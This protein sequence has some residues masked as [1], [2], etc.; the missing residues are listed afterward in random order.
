LCERRRGRRREVREGACIGAA[1]DEQGLR[2]GEW[3]KNRKRRSDDYAKNCP[4]LLLAIDCVIGE[5]FAHDVLGF[6]VAMVVQDGLQVNITTLEGSFQ[7]TLDA[8][9]SFPKA[10]HRVAGAG[11]KGKHQNLA[12]FPKEL[13]ALFMSYS[14]DLKWHLRKGTVIYTNQAFSWREGQG[15]LPKPCR[16]TPELFD[17]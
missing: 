1:T 4:I 7:G 5:P 6:R 3:T 2:D 12:A 16:V 9:G 15:T 14:F 11:A 10:L 8:A 13:F 17:L